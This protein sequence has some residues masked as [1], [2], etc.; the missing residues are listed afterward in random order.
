VESKWRIDMTWQVVD[1]RAAAVEDLLQAPVLFVSGRDGLRL[2]DQQKD[3]L[4]TFVDN[5]GFLLFESCCGGKAFDRQFRQLMKE[6][7]PDN[8]LHLLPP[9]HPVWY[10]EERVD[11]QY[12]GPLWGIDACCRTSVV[13]CPEDISCYWE[14]ASAARGQKYPRPIQ[15]RIDSALAAGTNILAYAT[16]RQ[17]RDKL[18]IQQVLSDDDVELSPARATL[19]IAKL[20]HGGGSDDAPAALINLLRMADYQVQLPVSLRRTLVSPSEESLPDY[21]ILFAHGRRTFR[22]SEAERQGLA[23]YL[24]AG[25][26][27]FA[28]SIC[29]SEEFTRSF[30]QEI[31]TILP[32]RPWKAIPPTHPMFTTE[33]GGYDVSRLSVREPQRRAAA[34]APLRAPVQ[35]TVPRLEGI[36]RDGRFVV[37]FSPLDISCALENHASLG[38][39]GYIREDA[40]K[41]GVNVIL[42]ALQ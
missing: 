7:F 24:A 20:R 14:L 29:A 25:G 16:N 18:D 23:N 21:P 3:N 8:P 38:C 13:Y 39:R 31:E 28:D 17:L 36:E 12:V 34:D 5:G 27:L 30:R 9:D 35:R 22:W 37:I 41:L 42:Y 2:S 32:G 11:P 1:V 4:R 19:R 33:F 26:V 40:A 15:R 10:A 6:M